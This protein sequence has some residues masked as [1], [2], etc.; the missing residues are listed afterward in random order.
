MPDDGQKILVCSKCGNIW[1]DT[2][3]DDGSLMGLEENGDW[4]DIVAWM[5]RPEPYKNVE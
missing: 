5:P 4:E 2:H 1:I 3:E